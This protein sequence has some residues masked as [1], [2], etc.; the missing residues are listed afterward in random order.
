MISPESQEPSVF[1][2][3]RYLKDLHQSWKSDR[4]AE[5]GMTLGQPGDGDIYQ[6]QHSED[7]TGL[8]KHDDDI[9]KGKRF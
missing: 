7:E 8:F 5:K 4:D 9:A 6:P 2:F 1:S 3:L